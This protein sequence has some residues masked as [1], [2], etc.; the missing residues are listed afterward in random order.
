MA[1]PYSGTF[2]R[3]GG[4][5]SALGKQIKLINLKPVKKVDISFDPF[6]A[7]ATA[8]R[9]LLFYISGPK[10]IRTNPNCRIKTNIVTDRSEPF[11]KL[12][13]TTNGII[14]LKAGNL[15]TLELL[16]LFNKH[17][18]SLVKPEEETENV[19]RTKSSKPSKQTKRK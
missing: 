3:S 16:Q 17:V 15:T 2:T 7:N 18:S 8:V 1:I 4:L 14:N 10:V 13:L 12:D 6:H 9:D 5:V 19:V 11:I